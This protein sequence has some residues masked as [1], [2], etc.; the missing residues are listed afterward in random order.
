MRE[1]T[2]RGF[3]CAVHLPHLNYFNTDLVEQRKGRS[4]EDLDRLRMA[5]LEAEF[6]RESEDEQEME[7]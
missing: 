4:V 3:Q 2:G 6:N 5:E 1:Y 7:A